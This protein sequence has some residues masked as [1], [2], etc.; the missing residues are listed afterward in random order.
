MPPRRGR[1]RTHPQGNDELN[2]PPPPPLNCEGTSQFQPNLQQVLDQFTRTISTTLP[3]RHH[4]ETLDI[5]RVREL[6]AC[7]F[8]GS[9]DPTK[10]KRWFTDIVRIFYVMKCPNEDRLRLAT[11]LLKRNAYYWW[12]IIWRGYPDPNTITWENFQLSLISS[13]ILALTGMPSKS[14]F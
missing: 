11:F 2:P 1:L 6:G 7:D 8:L 3:R 12:E 9:V 14:S 5:K 4:D 13:F 10:G